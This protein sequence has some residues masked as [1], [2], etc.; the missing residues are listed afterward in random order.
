[1]INISS[2]QIYKNILLEKLQK[3]KIWIVKLN[4]EKSAN[5][6][7][8]QTAD[9]LEK[10]F[11][12]FDNDQEACIAI[13][14]GEG[15]YFCSGAD[16]K[17]VD[18][19][20]KQI[21]QVEKGKFNQENS[22]SNMNRISKSE[23]PLGISRMTLSKPVIAAI[24]GTSVAGG[25]ELALWCD[26]RVTYKESILGV[27]CRRFGVPLIDGGTYRL[28][29]LMGMSRAMDL[30]LT[31]RP[32]SGQEAYD[33]GLVNR[34]V[35]KKEDVLAEAIKL[36]ESLIELPQICMRQDRLSLLENTYNFN[37]HK[38]IQNEYEHGLISLKSG[39]A[40]KGSK[41]FTQGKGRHGKALKEDNSFKPKF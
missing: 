13:L 22:S 20:L 36:A 15:K 41:L 12:L 27:F 5:A 34:V 28:S 24:N 18:R 29:A 4:R 23:A 19:N 6:I 38:M 21:L 14:T 26:L 16:L 10:V 7:D 25:F 1:M 2:N 11:K 8:K 32:I 31:G 39:E 30:I 3:G 33:I 9:E 35:D 37:L 40:V 17:Q